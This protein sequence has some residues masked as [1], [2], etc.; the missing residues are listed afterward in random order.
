MLTYFSDCYPN[1]RTKML[2]S[3]AST[4]FDRGTKENCQG[5]LKHSEAP[6]YMREESITSGYRRKLSY[7]ACVVR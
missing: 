5:L 6:L 4:A 1:S 3:E 2:W 7:S